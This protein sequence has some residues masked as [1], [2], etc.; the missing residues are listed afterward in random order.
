MSR[1][2]FALIYFILNLIIFNSTYANYENSLNAYNSKNW[3]LAYLECNND[4]DDKCLNLLGIL[5]LQGYGLTKNF[6]KAHDYFLKSE[7]MGNKSATFNLGW[8]A[9]MGLGETIN[10][11]KA[12]LYFN[13]SLKINQN[14]TVT[15]ANKQ[16]VE[17]SEKNLI[18]LSKNSLI[19]KYSLFYAD[20]LKLKILFNAEINNEKKYINDIS[21]IDMKLKDIESNLLNLNINIDFLKDGVAKDQDI[22]LKLLIIKLKNNYLEFEKEIHKTFLTLNKFVIDYN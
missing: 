15:K 4:N 10:F 16:L 6:N 7:E 2:I 13:K 19:A 18:K 20:Y 3:K 17:E 12:S 22:I 21:S 11:D 5:Y 9:L 14:Y 1:Y 8:M